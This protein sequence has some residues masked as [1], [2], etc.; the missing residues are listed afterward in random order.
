MNIEYTKEGFNFFVGYVK[1]KI[2]DN[3]LMD[4]STSTKSKRNALANPWITPGIIASINK[5]H[6]FYYKQWNRSRTYKNRAGNHDLCIKYK[7]F[8]S[9]LKNVINHAKK[10]FYCKK[11][12]KMKQNGNET[13]W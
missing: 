1:D 7:D 6:N 5:K 3:F 11:F 13:K 2:N 10:L 9:R 8:R 12:E 4:D